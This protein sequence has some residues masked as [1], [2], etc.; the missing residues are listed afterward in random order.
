VLEFFLY[1]K[2][3]PLPCQHWSPQNIISWSTFLPGWFWKGKII[4]TCKY[5]LK[6][7]E[8]FDQ[9]KF[10]L[11]DTVIAADVL[12]LHGC[13]SATAFLL[14][15]MPMGICTFMTKWAPIVYHMLYNNILYYRTEGVQRNHT[16]VKFELIIF[17]VQSKDGNADWTFPTVKDQS[18]LMI[19]HAKSNK[20]S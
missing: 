9:F 4:Y 2:W 15:V 19:S 18:Q 20:V 14:S 1:G 7:C 11:L 12:V 16:Y 5:C 10:D 17:Y 6:K 8:Y 13:R 3:T